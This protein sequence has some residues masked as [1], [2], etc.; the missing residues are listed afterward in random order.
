ML[1]RLGTRP[2]GTGGSGAPTGLRPGRSRS[3]PTG[4]PPRPDTLP[5]AGVLDVGWLL[6]EAFYD[7]VKGSA[8]VD[9]KI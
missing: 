9:L 7:E 5:N 1:G 4:W 3:S 6:D 2:L 8:D